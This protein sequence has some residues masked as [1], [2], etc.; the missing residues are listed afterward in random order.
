MTTTN[1]HTH[2]TRTVHVNVPGWCSTSDH[3]STQAWISDLLVCTLLR[4]VI[5]TGNKIVRALTTGRLSLLHQSTHTE[6]CDSVYM[7]MMT[8]SCTHYMRD[9]NCNQT[10]GSSKTA[11][12]C[13]EVHVPYTMSHTSSLHF[14]YTAVRTR[15]MPRRRNLT[16]Y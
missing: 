8:S 5:H 10:V 4:L 7:Y 13:I 3:F 15:T 2:N 16:S 6:Y 14:W 12:P 11:A 1:P 9:P